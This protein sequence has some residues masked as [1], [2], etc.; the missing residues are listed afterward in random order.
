[1][2]SAWL[3]RRFIDREARFKFVLGKGY[4]PEPGELRFDMFEA[5]YTHDG[6]RC[7]FEVLL[8]EFALADAAFGAISEIVHEIDL[9]DA[10]FGRADTLGIERLING[11]AMAN[12]DDEDRLAHGSAVFDGLYE[13]FKRKRSGS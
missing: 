10:K 2:A 1:M 3:I 4:R 8:R 7:T 6:D 9:K 13:Y 5:E 12:K 11:V